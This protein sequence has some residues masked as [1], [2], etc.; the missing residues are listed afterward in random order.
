MVIKLY[1]S[2]MST[3]RVL[4]TLLEKELPYEHILVDISKGDQNKEEYL[5][6]QPFGKVPVLD[7]NGFIMYESRAICRYLARKYDSGTKLIPDVDDHEAYGRF[8]QG[9]SI[10]YSY[11][12]A[13]AETLGTELVI[14]KYK[15]LGEPDMTRV[16]QAEADFDKVFF[17]YDKILAKQKYLTGDEIS[18]VDLFHLPNASALKAF[19]YQGT[20]EKYPNVNRWFSGLQA[21]ETWIKATAEAR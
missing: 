16:A 6:L 10:E 12:A 13:A 21:R 2:A 19:G 15:G 5:K 1:G 7:D 14:K 20:F 3:A 4:V 9:C 18:L 11:F 8:E 17:E